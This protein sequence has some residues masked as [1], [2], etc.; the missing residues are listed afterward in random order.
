MSDPTVLYDEIL[1]NGPSQST[2]Y[3]ILN[4]IRE[5]GRI[6]DVIKWCMAF[7]R[8]Y[9]KDIYL[10]M[11]LAESYFQM[12]SM[13]QAETEFVKVSSMM[14]DLL[15]VY[16]RLAEIYEKQRRFAEAADQAE[17]VLAHHPEN[18]QMRELLK[19][20]KDDASG[21][22]REWP[23][24]PDDDPES[25]VPFATPT[26]AEL[27]LSQGQLDAAVK[28][29]ERV[30]AAHPHDSASAQR[31]AQLKNQLKGAPAIAEKESA[32]VSLGEE[33]LLA[34]LEKWLPKVGE[35]KYA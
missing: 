7:L 34:V 35:I 29:Y 18:S 11:L 20:A 13:G 33:R 31:L 16:E 10:R 6:N 30:V 22:D 2:L 32:H 4:R 15:P 27:Y 24:L 8:V 28:T 23:A 17:I 26:I 19:R 9:P 5:E 1:R 14:N 12:G 25:P 3:L 21:R